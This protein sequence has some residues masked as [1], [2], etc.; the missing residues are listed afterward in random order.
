VNARNCPSRWQSIR[1]CCSTNAG[2]TP[3]PRT[4]FAITTP[5]MARL[6]PRI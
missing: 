6:H 2:R 4:G 5:V 3:S 1:I